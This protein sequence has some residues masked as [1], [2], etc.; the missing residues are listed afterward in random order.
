MARNAACR[1]QRQCIAAV[2]ACAAAGAEV[3]QQLARVD[4]PRAL[5][6]EVI[7]KSGPHRHKGH[8]R[9]LKR[10]KIIQLLN[11]FQSGCRDNLTHVA[12]SSH[13]L[14]NILIVNC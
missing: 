7:K 4:S 14:H 1:I 6:A 9:L 8:P 3:R 12:A 10:A 2:H 13:R 5:R 11:G